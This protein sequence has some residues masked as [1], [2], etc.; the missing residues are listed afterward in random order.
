MWFV[1]YSIPVLS[2]MNTREALLFVIHQCSL[3]E[4]W[5][6]QPSF[7]TCHS[8]RPS[9]ELLFK[10]AEMLTSVPGSSCW[11][12]NVCGTAQRAF[13]ILYLFS[14][15]YYK[16]GFEISFVI[17]VRGL[18]GYCTF[19]CLCQFKCRISFRPFNSWWIFHDHQWQSHFVI[20]SQRAWL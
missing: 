11:N 5:H 1:A 9:V 19:A 4:T 20:I 18:Y 7:N 6:S 15:S 8:V 17:I 14:L 16:S 12:H 2:F 13:T 3:N 10:P